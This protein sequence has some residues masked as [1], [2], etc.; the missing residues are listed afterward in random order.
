MARENITFS[1]IDAFRAFEESHPERGFFFK[2]MK[3]G[4]LY[5]VAPSDYLE[6]DT[7][8]LSFGDYKDDPLYLLW[9]SGTQEI[10]MGSANQG[11]HVPRFRAM[12]IHRSDIYDFS[13]TLLDWAENRSYNMWCGTATYVEKTE[14]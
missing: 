2:G 14:G 7:I 8:V 13:G 11:G 4:K 10:F 9:S 5:D 12:R 6:L 1:S 3:L